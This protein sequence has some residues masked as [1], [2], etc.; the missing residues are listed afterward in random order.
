MKFSK[1]Y[2][3]HP[4]HLVRANDN[5][6][7]YL[8]LACGGIAYPIDHDLSDKEFEE[9]AEKFETTGEI[10]DIYEGA[11]TPMLWEDFISSVNAYTYMD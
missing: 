7:N 6:M 2:N 5:A 9:Y 11:A 10:E 1:T 3:G 8:Y 4:A